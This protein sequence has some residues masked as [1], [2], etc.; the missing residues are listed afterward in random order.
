LN[1]GG[2][3]CAIVAEHAGISTNA[4]ESRLNCLMRDAGLFFEVIPANTAILANQVE[5]TKKKDKSPRPQNEESISC[6]VINVRKKW[7]DRKLSKMPAKNCVVL[8]LSTYYDEFV[9]QRFT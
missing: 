6:Y 4:E 5:N 7:G 2:P 1:R 8:S 3:S 9:R